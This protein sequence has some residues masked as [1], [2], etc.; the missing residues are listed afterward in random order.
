M[1]ARGDGY[2]T[3]ARV[4]HVSD[5]THGAAKD[6]CR[7]HGLEM[8]SWLSGLVADADA[9]MRESGARI[10]WRDVRSARDLEALVS[11]LYRIEESTAFE[12]ALATYGSPV[13]GL[14]QDARKTTSARPITGRAQ[15]RP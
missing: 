2:R 3:D 9:R 7:A 12:T 14:A 1:T 13:R 8:T 5:E 6:F 4:V 10:S 11:S 15:S